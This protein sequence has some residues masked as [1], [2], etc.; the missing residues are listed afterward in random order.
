MAARLTLFP[1]LAADVRAESVQGRE[2][3]AAEIAAM[4]RSDAPVLTGAYRDGITVRTYGERVLVVD[5]DDEAIFK[6]YGTVDTP[7][8]AALTD[9]ARAFGRYSGWEPR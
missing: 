8:H 4:A 6:E 1:N 5:D 7:A 3:I 9:A 2:E